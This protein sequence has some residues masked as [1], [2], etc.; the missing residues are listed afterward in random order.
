MAK[1]AL[2]F[3]GQSSQYQGMGKELLALFPE[4]EYIYTIGSELVGFD[5]KKTCFE[6][7]DV[8]LS[9]TEIAQPA[10]FATSILAY[11]AVK[12][13]GITVD[14]VAGHSLGEYA[15]MVCSGMLS[16]EDG[17]KII[18]ARAEAM[19]R[20]ANAQNSA[21]CA[22]LGLPSDEIASICES[23]DAYVI[24]VNYNSPA[25]TVIAGESEAVEA[26]MAKFSEM[27]NRTIK[28]AVS[29]AF[30]SKLMQSGAD[31]FTSTIREF[32]FSAPNVDFFSNV[33]GEKLDDFSDMV[34]YLGKHLVSP[35]R[36]VDELNAMQTAG[37][38]R[39]IECGPNKVLTGLVKKTLSDIT[40]F[41]VE[42]EKTFLKLKESL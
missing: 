29:A 30:H 10:I 19:G 20:C 22:V 35:V 5:L 33:S 11:E 42:N 32:H 26:A 25:Q 17:F 23:I 2:L 38:T 6:G 36:F 12:K 34:S 27:G 3:S 15:A 24:P 13:L 8:T 16:L 39:F 28:L 14:M 7:S 41:N 21:M 37:A 40:A 4:L 18:K 31:E 1:T 9:K